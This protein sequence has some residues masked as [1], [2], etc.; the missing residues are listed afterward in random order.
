MAHP[1]RRHVEEDDGLPNP[2]DVKR[3]SEPATKR[4]PHCKKEVYEDTDICY[5]CGLAISGSRSNQSTIVIVVVILVVF[6]MIWTTLRG[7][8][9]F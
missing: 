9:L 2:E 6:A 3:L 1:L 5:H 7:G 8:R 4:C